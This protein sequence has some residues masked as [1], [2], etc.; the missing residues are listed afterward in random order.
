MK[1]TL[2][3]LVNV[4]IISQLSFAQSVTIVPANPAS[5]TKGTMVYDN[6][7]NQLQYWNNSAWIPITNAASGTGWALTGNH[8]Y[9]SNTGF[10]GIGT[11]NPLH[12]LSVVTPT[13]AYG[14]THSDGNITMGSWLTT[15]TAQFGTK[16]NHPL[17]FFTNNG[18]AQMTILPNG[19]V[20][21][22]I[23][24]GKI[25]IGN[26]NPSL[27][28]DIGTRIR[29]REEDYHEGID[30]A[31]AFALA[32][33]VTITPTMPLITISLESNFVF[34]ALNIDD[35][36]QGEMIVVYCAIGNLGILDAGSVIAPGV[37]SNIKLKESNLILN[38]HE[39]IHLIFMDGLWSEL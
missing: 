1:K 19:N 4:L 16:S 6:V 5:P 29:L 10:V 7:I 9:S 18:A 33:V 30:H 14:L 27:G 34:R 28:L 26:S 2:V 24:G 22:G 38:S 20:G 15:T 31:S 21:I 11:T 25:G 32:G 35:G 17:E 3:I 23:S 12:K 13:F 37:Y 8:I 36:I 39:S